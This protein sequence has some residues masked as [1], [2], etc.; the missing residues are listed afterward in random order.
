MN[1]QSAKICLIGGSGRSGTTIVKTIFQRHPEVAKVP[2][3]R[4]AIDPDGLIDFYSTFSVIWSPYLFDRKIRRLRKLLYTIGRGSVFKRGYAYVM[5][6]T[7]IESYS[8][9]CI[10]P[11]YAGLQACKT[12][13]RFLEFV[14]Q[15]ID[16]LTSFSYGG[17]WNGS[18]FLERNKLYYAYFDGPE[19]LAKVI[20]AFWEKVIT[21]T[22]AAQNTPYY[23][24]DNTWNILYFDKTRQM[25]PQAKL[26]HVYREPRDVIA[27]YS[28]MRWAPNDPAEAAHWYKGVLSQ[29]YAVRQRLEPGSYMEVALEDLVAEPKEYLEEICHFWGVPWDDVLL[30]TDLSK[31]HSGRW[32]K[33]FDAPAI[34]AIDRVLADLPP[35]KG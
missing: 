8:P 1:D 2:E 13:P 31:S 28:K 16:E 22:C 6:K 24:E 21:D 10:V 12:S 17:Q 34:E 33:D 15:L 23:V 30:E 35:V 29:W 5:Q 20:G 11:Q 19:D 26:L 3:W 7:G 32:K 14:D 9:F 25:L 4:F 18:R 27:S